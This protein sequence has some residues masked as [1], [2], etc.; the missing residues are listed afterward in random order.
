M[1]R[2][3]A[4][5]VDLFTGAILTKL[6]D[7]AYRMGLLEAPALGPA[8]SHELAE[9]A[10]LNERY[11]REWLGAMVTSGVLVHDPA[12]DRTPFPENTRSSSQAPG[13]ETS[14]P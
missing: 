7:I 14:P 6:I 8:T 4:R 13:V 10:R 9:R 5:L 2:F 11:V 1:K 12:S 3:A